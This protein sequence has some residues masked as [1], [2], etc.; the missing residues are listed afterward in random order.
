MVK[1]DLLT[2][3]LVWQIG[4]GSAQQ[5][6]AAATWLGARKSS[7]HAGHQLQPAASLQRLQPGLP[8]GPDLFEA[9]PE[10]PGRLPAAADR[11]FAEVGHLSLVHCS[12]ASPCMPLRASPAA[13]RSTK[14]CLCSFPSGRQLPQ[15]E[16]FSH[17][18]R[19]QPLPKPPLRG[20][21]HGRLAH[22]DLS[23]N[24]L[25]GLPAAIG[26]C[27]ALVE[28]LLGYNRL[29]SVPP[30]L[31][32]LAALRTLDLRGNRCV[33]ASPWG[34]MAGACVVHAGIPGPRR[35]CCAEHHFWDP[36]GSIKHPACVAWRY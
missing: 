14:C 32:A 4:A 33:K 1:H 19:L 6:S 17:T 30:E 7:A 12:H 36:W 8:A 10:R 34:G 22:L 29:E 2:C 27:T 24:R 28:L 25:S 3:M 15:V 5:H 13:W 35:H 21:L 18:S 26:R 16:R 23:Q 9:L 11:R 31:G 20:W